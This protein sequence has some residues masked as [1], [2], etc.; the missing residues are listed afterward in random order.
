MSRVPE[1]ATA[2]AQRKAH[3]TMNV[4][5]RWS[6][7]GKDDA[8]IGWARKLFED[9]AAD[10]AGSVYVN[11]MPEDEAGRVADAY[12]QNLDRLR[13]VK[14]EYDPGSLFRVNHNIRPATAEQAAQ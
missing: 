4:H 12:G 5:T 2:F 1:H 8:C 10:A 13:A 11:F 9:T 6:D 7:A 3:F 14:A